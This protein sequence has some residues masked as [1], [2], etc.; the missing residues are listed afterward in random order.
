MSWILVV[1]DEAAVTRL[2]QLRL[3]NEGYDVEVAANGAAALEK[4]AARDY[5][6]LVTDLCMPQLGGQELVEA[7]RKQTHN[8]GL[9]IFVLSS[10]PEEEYRRWTEEQPGVTFLEKPVSLN[11]LVALIQEELQGTEPPA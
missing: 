6:V 7:V 5:D 9:R 10:R 8:E 11:R 3:E 1:D 2:V 4:L